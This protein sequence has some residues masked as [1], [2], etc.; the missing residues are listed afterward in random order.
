MKNEI[1]TDPKGRTLFNREFASRSHGI[2]KALIRLKESEEKNPKY[3]FS[4]KIQFLLFLFLLDKSDYM[5]M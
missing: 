3:L 5:Q 2:E 1:L 4:F